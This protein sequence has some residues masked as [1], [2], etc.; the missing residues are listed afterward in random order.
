MLKNIEKNEM[1]ILWI[2]ADLQRR[3]LFIPKMVK[4]NSKILTRA[5]ASLYL[6]YKTRYP[7]FKEVII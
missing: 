6:E 7:D 5:E 2:L 3:V 1:C 4:E